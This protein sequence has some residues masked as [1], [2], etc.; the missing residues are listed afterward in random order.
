MEAFVL[1][2]QDTYL[3]GTYSSQ[4]SD[5]YIQLNSLFLIVFFMQQ[6]TIFFKIL[7]F[8]V[9]VTGHLYVLQYY[10][11]FFMFFS[12]TV[13]SVRE[14]NGPCQYLLRALSE[15]FLHVKVYGL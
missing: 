2:Q 13:C 7:F 4:S 15:K 11:V 12:I 3:K 1:Y 5:I 10:R 6:N 14:D 8:N 9:M